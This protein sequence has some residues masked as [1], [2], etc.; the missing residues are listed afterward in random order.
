[1]NKVSELKVAVILKSLSL[2]LLGFLGI[3]L[4]IPYFSN[5]LEH[6]NILFSL[7]NIISSIFISCGVL[8]ANIS[9]NNSYTQALKLFSVSLSS[10]STS[11]LALDSLLWIID[12]A[13]KLVMS[14]EVFVAFSNG[15]LDYCFYGLELFVAMKLILAMPKLFSGYMNYF[16]PSEKQEPV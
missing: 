9:F 2:I 8:I 1:M 14:N 15:Y 3:Y 5:P 13:H 16:Q 12:Y 4:S 6:G 7:I 10:I 11:I